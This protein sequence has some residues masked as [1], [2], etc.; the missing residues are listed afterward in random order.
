[1]ADLFSMNYAENFRK[2]E[3]E[4]KSSMPITYNPF[5]YFYLDFNSYSLS[6][7]L[8][9]LEVIAAIAF[10]LN[11]MFSVAMI[12]ASPARPFSIFYQ[13][14]GFPAA[15][16][17]MFAL[18]FI[19]AAVD[20]IGVFIFKQHEG[21]LSTVK[22]NAVAIIVFLYYIIG[23]SFWYHVTMMVYAARSAG[24]DSFFSP[25]LAVSLLLGLFV[26][27]TLAHT[28]LI[29][30]AVM[31]KLHK[32]NAAFA[33]KTMAVLPAACLIFLFTFLLVLYL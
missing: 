16:I 10:V 17:F 27:I 1:M 6:N 23:L 14:I 7:I 31:I 19:T 26:L 4:Q 3:I 20:H 5:R 28:F 22:A 15:M 33:A 8:V 29:K 30:L 13:I 24:F 12:I 25:P 11:M 9:R 2:E 21:Y 32:M 18:P